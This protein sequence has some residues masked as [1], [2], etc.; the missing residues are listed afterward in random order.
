MSNSNGELCYRSALLLVCVDVLFFFVTFKKCFGGF[1]AAT[2]SLFCNSQFQS[3]YVS[4]YLC[5]TYLN[6]C[7]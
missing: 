4:L 2:F 6:L 7:V 3:S 5:R 1:V